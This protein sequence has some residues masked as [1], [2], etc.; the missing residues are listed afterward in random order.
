VVA[1]AKAI[2]TVV[3]AA[4]PSRVDGEA[5]DDSTGAKVPLSVLPSTDRV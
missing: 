2:V 3:F 4:G 1:A 5:A